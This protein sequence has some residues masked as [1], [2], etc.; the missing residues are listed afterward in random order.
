L[1]ITDIK[2]LVVDD[3]KIMLNLLRSTFEKSGRKV[4]TAVD[5][6]QAIDIVRKKPFDIVIT[7]INMPRMDGITLLKSIKKE[8]PHIIVIII[9]GFASL[10]SAMTAIKEGAYDY[11]AK[12]F[13]IEEVVHAVS[14]AK[15]KIVLLKQN[16]I[17]VRRL[18][19]AY[20]RIK[21]LL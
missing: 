15:E 14:R 7:D 9:T 3:D 6:M 4:D 10:D 13:Q 11:I 12:P 20:E 17:L 5:G 2:L 1:E 21:S 19:Q 16:E 18:E 8:F